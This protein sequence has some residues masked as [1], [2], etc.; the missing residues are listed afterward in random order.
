MPRMRAASARADEGSV[1]FRIWRASKQFLRLGLRLD[2]AESPCRISQD[3]TLWRPM[4]FAIAAWLPSAC[5]E[6]RN[7]SLEIVCFVQLLD[8]ASQAQLI[9][10]LRPL[11]R[12]FGRVAL[13]VWQPRIQ[14]KQ[15][16]G[17]CGKTGPQQ[18]TEMMHH[19]EQ[20]RK[21]R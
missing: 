15:S 20:M 1:G 14:G 5:V 2:G 21:A 3:Q 12:N 17:T 11:A 8:L 10:S 4:N 18:F 13:H 7:A 19:A 6:F 9:S 16:Q